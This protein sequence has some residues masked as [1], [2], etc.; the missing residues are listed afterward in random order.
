MYSEEREEEYERAKRRIFNDAGRD[1]HMQAYKY[2][3]NLGNKI[4]SIS[5]ELLCKNAD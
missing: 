5:Y 4:K 1:H 2:P 3:I